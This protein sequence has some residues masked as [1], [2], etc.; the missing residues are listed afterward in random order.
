MMKNSFKKLCVILCFI[1]LVAMLVGC[2]SGGGNSS[3]TI[4]NQSP[5]ANA[6]DNKSV[7]E[8]DSVSLIG[9]GTDTDGTII[10]YVWIQTSGTNVVT[11]SDSTES[12]SFT[13]WAME[14]KSILDKSAVDAIQITEFPD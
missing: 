9:S 10:S 8:G 4:T 6:G 14:S 2:S 3:S 13:A 1:N 5:I 11:S 7:N 12:I